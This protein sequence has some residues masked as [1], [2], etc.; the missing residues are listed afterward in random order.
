MLPRQKI[1]K[2]TKRKTVRNTLI[3]LAIIGAGA[4]TYAGYLLYKADTALENMS[5]PSGNSTAQAAAPIVDAQLMKPMSFLLAGVDS[6]D[7]SGGSMNT[8]VLMLVSLNPE[9]RAATIVSIPRDLQMNPKAYGLPSHKANYYYAYYNNQDKDTALS[10]TKQL[11]SNMFNVPIDYMAVIDFDGF[12]EVVDELNGIEVNVDTDMRYVDTEDGT[13][14][15]L[16]KG[17]QTLSGKETLD[18]LRYRKSNRGTD[19][20]SDT[21]RNERQQLVLDKLLSQMTS[22][23]GITQWGG[24]LE[25]AGRNVKTDIPVDTLRKFILSFQKLKPE[26]LEFIHLDGRWDSPYIVPKEEDL[27]AAVAALR[28]QLGLPAQDPSFATVTG[29]TYNAWRT[30]FGID[31]AVTKSAATTQRTGG[32][33]TRE[34]NKAR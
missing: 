31:P 4:L 17:L 13:D 16:K 30:K 26:Q 29:S 3:S 11:Y 34:V 6:R 15:N 14:I 23:G 7:G 9:R 12:R 2:T 1:K 22:L 27:T 20:S 28:T 24:I 10:K 32:S 5:L 8:D 18:F 33:N 25:I 19:E 21:A